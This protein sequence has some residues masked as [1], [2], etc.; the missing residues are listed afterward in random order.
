MW[1]NKKPTNCF[2]CPC[3]RNEIE[4]CCGLDDGTNDYFLD[5]IDGDNCPMKSIQKHDDKLLTKV[6]EMLVPKYDE[7]NAM[8]LA[9]ILRQIYKEQKYE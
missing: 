2:E 8:I 7:K 5:E 4:C 3:F 9:D 1:T 6:Y